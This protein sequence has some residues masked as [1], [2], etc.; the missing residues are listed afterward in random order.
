MRM[1]KPRWTFAALTPGEEFEDSYELTPDLVRAYIAA[2]GDDHPWY[3]GPSPFGGPIA[4]PGLVAFMH[5]RLPRTRYDCTGA[6]HAKH[7]C[8]HIAP[9]LVGARLRMRGWLADKY[10]KRGRAYAAIAFASQDQ[11]GRLI[12]RGQN[13]WVLRLHPAAAQEGT[14]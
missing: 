4:P 6:V 13:T 3:T 11:D 12:C 5:Y 9:A 1:T 8:E 7:A 10:V 14:S 2:T